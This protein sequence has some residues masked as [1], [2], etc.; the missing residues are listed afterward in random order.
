[1]PIYGVVTGHSLLMYSV[2]S[3]SGVSFVGWLEV[4]SLMYATEPMYSQGHPCN[5]F[6]Q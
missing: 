2:I 4:K 6:N 5:D 1:M 3:V